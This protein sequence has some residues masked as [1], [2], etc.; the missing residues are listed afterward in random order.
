MVGKIHQNGVEI[1]VKI[2]GL[3][4]IDIAILE[5]RFLSI[6]PYRNI[7]IFILPHISSQKLW[8]LNFSFYFYPYLPR[9]TW[10]QTVSSKNTPPQRLHKFSTSN[11][12]S[13]A[14]TRFTPVN[15][16][17]YTY[18][19]MPQHIFLVVSEVSKADDFY[20]WPFFY[21]SNAVSK[22]CIIG[23]AALNPFATSFTKFLSLLSIWVNSFRMTKL[24][25]FK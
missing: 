2:F 1:W 7:A 6:I 21:P 19:S 13:L 8:I 5:Y 16:I 25:N 22:N 3:I 14:L 11:Y 4:K 17:L 12:L 20:H 10:I 24:F 9:L 23:R 18:L 15:P